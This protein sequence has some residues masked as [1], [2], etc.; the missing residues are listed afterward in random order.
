MT[1]SYSP[2]AQKVPGVRDPATAALRTIFGYLIHTTGGGVV[3]RATLTG[4]TPLQVA[5]DY[6]IAS[7][8]G[9]NGYL[10]GGP[11]YVI[12]YDGGTYQLAPDEIHMNHA[13]DHSPTY[14][15]GTRGFYL[16]GTWEKMVSPETLALWKHAWPGRKHPY[17]LFPSVSPN[18]DYVGVEII[19][20]G[21]GFGGDPMFP[22]G[23]FTR[24]QHDAAAALGRDLGVRHALPNG[25]QW[26]N[27]L[28]GH[29][30]VDPIQRSDAHGGW[31]PG[32]LRAHI[33]FDMG[34][35]R[36]RIGTP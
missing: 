31:D 16:D 33:Y 21:E 29:E 36:E 26:T 8:N 9:A 1:L 27:R 6:Y 19:P 20:I 12:D 10:W 13:G 4:R 15:H 3:H 5:I 11:S 35:V 34:Y 2:I 30:D 28:V 17:S 22:G 18:D 32:D 7:Q 24:A 14:P 23:K 25:W